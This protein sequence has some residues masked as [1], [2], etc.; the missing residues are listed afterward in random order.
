MN[1]KGVI[2][3]ELGTRTIKAGFAGSNSPSIEFPAE[4]NGTYPINSG[5]DMNGVEVLLGRVFTQL[6]VDLSEYC[7]F[8]AKQ[9]LY[10]KDNQAALG[11][12]LF[13]T[14]N[15][16]AIFFMETT[17]LALITTGKITGLV[18]HS[19]GVQM[20]ISPYY[21]GQDFRT[22]IIRI[23]S[24][25]TDLAGSGQLL[26]NSL[27][28]CEVHMRPELCF[29][30]VFSGEG[31]FSNGLVDRTKNEL[32]ALVPNGMKIK[33][34]ASPERANAAWIGG[35]LI[36]E[37]PNFGLM[38]VSKSEYHTKGINAVNKF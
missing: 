7:I 29:N 22:A 18:L 16:G 14:F 24:P 33:M 23:D 21:E 34:V 4:V 31:T 36:S 8:I 32:S 38:C 25:P 37:L 17:K 6:N 15:A 35:G 13:D 2:L 5:L 9:S 28:K 12:M 11:Q 3:I 1:L 10:R 20:H 30:V 26:Y 27:M 19:E